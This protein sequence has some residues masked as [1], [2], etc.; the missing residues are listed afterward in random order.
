[1]RNFQLRAHER[2]THLRVVSIHAPE[3]GCA[4][5][6]CT[7]DLSR[8]GCKFYTDM[9]LSVGDAIELTWSDPAVTLGGRVVNVS[10]HDE[11]L[12]AGVRFYQP[13]SPGAFEELQQ[14]RPVAKRLRVVQA[15]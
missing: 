12:F 15:G 3:H 13:L 4:D 11:G 14:H 10:P 5:D 9:P 7:I 1:M 8:G 2:I 6:G